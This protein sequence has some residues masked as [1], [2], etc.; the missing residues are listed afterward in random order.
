MQPMTDVKTAAWKILDTRLPDGSA[1]DLWIRDGKIERIVPTAADKKP[2]TA[3]TTATA[4][5]FDAGGAL[6]LPGLVDGHIHLDKALVGV[7]W[8]PHV[9]VDSRPERI[10]QEKRALAQHPVPL[11]TRAENL[12]KR[13]IAYGTTHLRCHVD[14]DPELG[15]KHLQALCGLRD[16][17][18]DKIYM[19]FVAFPQSGV[20]ARPGTLEL[21][22]AALGEGAD[23]IGGL[24]PAGYDHDVTGQLDGIFLI[25]RRRGVRV[26]IHLHDPGMLGVFELEQIARRTVE[27]GL[28]ERVVVSHAYGLGAVPERIVAQ[29]ADMLARAGIAIVTNAPGTGPMPPVKEL[30]RRGVL[31][32][33]GSDNIR[34]CWW[35]Y[36]N[37]DMLERAQVIGYRQDLFTDADLRLAC[38]MAT[39]AAARALGIADYGLREGAAADLVL[40]ESPCVPQA[41]VDH[42]RRKL[43]VKSGRIVAR[44][45][46]L[47]D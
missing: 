42:P 1:A 8:M 33:A 11:A 36:G 46:A 16:K 38:E 14:I 28:Q 22:D 13:L 44:D 45:G 15:L 7:D 3:T 26:D 18:R 31:M 39:T 29:A 24:D 32:F 47:V 41:V 23:L 6:V 25:A 20:M 5:D 2:A 43:V 17:Y 10:A 27:S 37:G 12:L 35:P 4:T 34:D 30:H 19:E 21:L 40:V 9:E